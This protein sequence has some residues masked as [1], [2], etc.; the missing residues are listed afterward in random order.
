MRVSWVVLSYRLPREPSRLRLAAWR[1]LKRLAAALLHDALWVLPADAR[2]HEAFEWL[3]EEIGEAGGTVLTFEAQSFGAA[4][5]AAMVA[6]FTAEADARYGELAESARAIHRVWARRRPSDTARLQQVRRQLA[7]L[8]RAL[9]LERRRDYFRARG[10]SDAEAAIRTARDL[11]ERR[12]QAA[13][14]LEWKG[15]SGAVGH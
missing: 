2:T 11:L 4:Q 10:R 15:A 9:R 14:P 7:G 5:D 6:A 3:A 13:S 8:E 1:R 12:L